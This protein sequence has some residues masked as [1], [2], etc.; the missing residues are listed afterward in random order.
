M[1]ADPWGSWIYVTNLTFFQSKKIMFNFNK[2]EV[3][4]IIVILITLIFILFMI[5]YLTFGS[6]FY[7]ILALF[8][9]PGSGSGFRQPIE[10]GPCGSGSETLQVTVPEWDCRSEVKKIKKQKA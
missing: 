4:I 2:T 3:T 6:V 7:F 5:N 9:P 10:C 8:G 1:N